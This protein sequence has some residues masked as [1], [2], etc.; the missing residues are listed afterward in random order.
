MRKLT[1]S[2]LIIMVS[3]TI[4]FSQPM[5]NL[6][7]FSDDGNPFY[8]VMNGIKENQS[9]QT[10]VKIPNLTAP[11]YKVK[12]IFEDKTIPGVEKNVYTKPDMEVTYVI[13]QNKKGENV[14]RYYSEAP[15]VFE[16]VEEIVVNNHTDANNNVHTDVFVHE[17]V[18]DN[19]GGVHIDVNVNESG[20]SYNVETDEG[21]VNVNANVDVS[22][23]NISYDANVVEHD[24]HVV[25]DEGYRDNTVYVMPGY[26]GPVGCD[27]PMNSGDFQR[28]KNTIGNADFED[29][30]LTIAKQVIGMNCLTVDQVKEI[31]MLFDFEDT[32]LEYAKF[33]YGRTFDIGN[34][35]LLNDMFDFSSSIDELNDYINSGR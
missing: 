27:W 15:A 35:Y 10:N 22:G 24:T 32:K 20:I 33:A 26:N 11:A 25:V 18:H 2:L 6:V 17:E 8:V 7:F 14:L 19:S 31:G 23:T 12:I 3:A 30:K 28:A 9:A 29:D 4:A 1:L 34:Y 13:K 5:S 21:S 16:T